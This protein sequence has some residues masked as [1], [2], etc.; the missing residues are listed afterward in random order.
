[1]EPCPADGNPYEGEYCRLDL[2]FALFCLFLMY[3]QTAQRQWHKQKRLSP[4]LRRRWFSLRLQRLAT[5]G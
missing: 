5:R 4:L 1:M 2:R 3:W